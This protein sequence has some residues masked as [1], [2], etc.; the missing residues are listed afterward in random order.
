MSV[1]TTR[2]GLKM[3]SRVRALTVLA[4]LCSLALTGCKEEAGNEARTAA[5]AASGLSA[6][7]LK[8]A[9]DVYKA[10][11][12]MCHGTNGQ[13]DGAAA[14]GLNPAPKNFQDASWQGSVTDQDIEKIVEA[15]GPAV[16]KSA[17]M[18]PNPDLAGKPVV[19]GL[20]ALVRAMGA[21]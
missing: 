11:C 16:G 20:R 15:G 21:Q 2:K 3:I 9:Q 4:A 17:A 6:D 12:A 18:P 5:L 19:A 10:R 7:V 1:P 13:G 8:E 14:A